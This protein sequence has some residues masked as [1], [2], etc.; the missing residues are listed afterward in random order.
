[1]ASEAE[2]A[3]FT[4]MYSC[5]V[6]GLSERSESRL[7]GG[8][9]LEDEMHGT[10]RDTACYLKSSHDTLVLSPLLDGRS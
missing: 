3:F 5:I 9:G 6:M 4:S 8:E 2:R 10:K 1:M 7:C